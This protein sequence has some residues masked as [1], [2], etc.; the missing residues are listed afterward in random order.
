MA[1]EDL[2]FPEDEPLSPAP[3]GGAAQGEEEAISLVESEG[4]EGQAATV[5]AFGARGP[6][7]AERE[8]KR[9]LNVTGQGATRCRVFHSK[10]AEAALEFMQNQING[11]LDGEEIEVKHVGHVI[12]TMEGKTPVP[13]LLVLVWY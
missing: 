1:E 2:T 11:W 5:R 10:I 6:K 13:N 4:E 8:L 3:A 9:A 7:R 12:G